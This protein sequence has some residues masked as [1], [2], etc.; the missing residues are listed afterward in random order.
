MQNLMRNDKC[1]GSNVKPNPKLKY[2]TPRPQAGLSGN[3]ISLINIVPLTPLSRQKR[4][5]VHSGQK[6]YEFEI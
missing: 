1:Q 6:S 4:D 3:V 2:E 5:G